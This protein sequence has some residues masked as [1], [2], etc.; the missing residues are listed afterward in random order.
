MR[1]HTLRKITGM[2]VSLLFALNCIVPAAFS[3][4]NGKTHSLRGYTEASA[5][6]EFEWEAKMRG[7][8]KPQ[9]LREYMNRLAAEPHHVGSAYD[10]QNAEFIRDKVQ[11]WGL[12]THP[13]QF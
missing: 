1:R 12:H 8:P 3:Q 6:T 5:K 11:S 4:A 10:K 7:L 9:V 2:V 13:E